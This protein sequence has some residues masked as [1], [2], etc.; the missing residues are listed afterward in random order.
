MLHL[1]PACRARASTIGLL[2]ENYAE[3][4]ECPRA[5]C[6]GKLMTVPAEGHLRGN[7]L[8]VTS[9]F[10]VAPTDYRIKIPALARNS[11]AEFIGVNSVRS[12]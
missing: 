1:V 8:V 6:T 2:N 12:T 3:L 4:E 9:N 7:D 5:R 10:S 11:I